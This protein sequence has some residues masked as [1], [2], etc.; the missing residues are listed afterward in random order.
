MPGV[1]P[2]PKDDY[3][4]SHIP[5]AVFFERRCGVRSFQSAAAHVPGRRA[6]SAAMSARSVIGKR[7]T[8]FVLY[9]AGGWVAAPGAAWW[10]FP[11]VR[12]PECPRAQWRPEEVGPPKAARSE[13]G[14]GGA[15]VK[16]RSRRPSIRATRAASSR[17]SPTL[18]SRAEQGDR[19]APPTSAIRARWPSRRPGLRSRP[20]SRQ[21]ET[22]PTTSCSTPRLARLKSLDE[23]R[24]AFLGAGRESSMRRS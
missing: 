15:Q 10:M 1:L 8:R 6:V 11:V 12:T 16:P 23:L 18:A 3:L 2:L 5:G 7:P 14:E 17:W 13:S 9:D 20:Y 21:P 19:C 4:G 24:A 22:C